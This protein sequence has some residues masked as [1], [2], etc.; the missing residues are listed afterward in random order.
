DQF[1][2]ELAVD[3][4]PGDE[5]A[6]DISHTSSGEQGQAGRIPGSARRQVDSTAQHRGAAERP[7]RRIV[8]ADQ[9]DVGDE[10]DLRDLGVADLDRFTRGKRDRRPGLAH[11][12]GALSVE[13]HTELCGIGEYVV[14]AAV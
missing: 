7:V 5:T 11:L 12:A 10:I 9:H 8:V 13:L 4:R 2:V 6:A 14:A 1:D 3:Q